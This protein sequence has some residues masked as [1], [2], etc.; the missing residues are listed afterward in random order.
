MKKIIVLIVSVVLF[1]VGLF[2][3]RFINATQGVLPQTENIN[4]IHSKIVTFEVNELPEKQ[5]EDNVQVETITPD[6]ITPNVSEQVVATEQQ[7]VEP[8]PVSTPQ[9]TPPAQSQAPESPVAP[10]K[11]S[12]SDTLLPAPEQPTT[13]EKLTENRTEFDINYWVSYAKNY[14]QSIGLQLYETAAA[15]WDNPVSANPNRQGIQ[16]DI[17]SRLNR[18][19]NIENSTAVWICY[20]QISDNNYNIYIGY[21]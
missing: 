15:C 10:V 16:Q 18:Y 7:I 19:K 3:G 20:E 8:A 9:P 13:E 11:H 4:H 2:G 1:T 5:A 14:A 17:E 12:K 21:A 6:I